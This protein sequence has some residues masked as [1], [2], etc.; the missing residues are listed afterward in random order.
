M[1]HVLPEIQTELVE[2]WQKGEMHNLPG[3][4]K[5]DWKHSTLRLQEVA[6][7]PR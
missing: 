6:D 1:W 5:E 7:F 2:L 4:S 3:M